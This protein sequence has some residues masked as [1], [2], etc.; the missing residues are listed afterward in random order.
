VDHLPPTGERTKTPQCSH[1]KGAG[2]N[3]YLK[4]YSIQRGKRGGREWAGKQGGGGER[5][6][7]RVPPYSKTFLG[8]EDKSLL[9]GVIVNFA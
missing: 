6:E 5:S 3:E 9:K 4:N 2:G 1:R 8:G 7:E